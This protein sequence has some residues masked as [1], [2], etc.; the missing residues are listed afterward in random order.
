MRNNLREHVSK[1]K[2]ILGCFMGFC[3]GILIIVCGNFVSNIPDYSS[4]FLLN[5]IYWIC[6]YSA[7]MAAILAKLILGTFLNKWYAILLNSITLMYFSVL[8]MYLVV[9][10]RRDKRIF[11]FVFVA[12]LVVHGVCLYLF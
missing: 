11:I 6:T 9:L 2:P 10:F 4:S 5:S 12:L 1:R 3:F 8:G 7:S